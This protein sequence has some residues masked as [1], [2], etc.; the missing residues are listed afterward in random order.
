[1]ARKEKKMEEN[2]RPPAW[3]ARGH[4]LH[5]TSSPPPPHTAHISSLLL[6]A[7][8]WPLANIKAIS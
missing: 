2:R 4:P 6:V 1:M 5:K 7:R 3:K 8:S